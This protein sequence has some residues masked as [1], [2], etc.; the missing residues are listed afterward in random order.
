MRGEGGVNTNYIKFSA[1]N[2]KENQLQSRVRNRRADKRMAK[3]SEGSKEEH[4]V[5][6]CH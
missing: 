4:P 6:A 3:V 1:L 5:K 2:N